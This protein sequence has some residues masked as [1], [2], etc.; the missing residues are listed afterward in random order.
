MPPNQRAGWPFAVGDRVW[1]LSGTHKNTVSTVYAVWSERGQVRVDLGTE[2][3]EKVEDVYSAVAV[4]RARSTEGAA[5]NG[6]PGTQLGNSE[7]TEGP[8]S[9]NRWAERR[10]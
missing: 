5:P 9:V 1:I 7:V 10:H 3:R 8:S 2:A 4:C 6:G